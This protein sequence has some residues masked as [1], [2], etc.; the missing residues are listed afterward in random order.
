MTAAQLL[1]IVVAGWGLTFGLEYFL[2]PRP[3]L[4]ARPAGAH[5]IHLGLWLFAVGVPLFA[6][7]RPLLILALALA[8]WVVIVTVS[9]V[10]HDRLKEPL[11]FTDLA[12]VFY[13]TRHPRLYV[14]FFGVARFLLCGGV[15][16][17]VAFGLW[18]LEQGGRSSLPDVWLALLAAA[19]ALLGALLIWVG[20]RTA[21]EPT[22]DPVADIRRFGLIATLWLYRRVERRPRTGAVVTPFTTASVETPD[23]PDLVAIQSESFFDARR[24][25]PS[26]RPDVL[27]NFD[28]I[29][30]V[31]RAEG[32][33]LVPAWGANTVRTEFSFLSGLASEALGIDRFNP[34]RRLARGP[35]VTLVGHL[36]RLGY[37]TVCVHPYLSS[38]YARNQVFP[39]LGFDD[40]ID[41]RSFS[42]SDRVGPYVGDAAV[43]AAIM[44]L[45]GESDRPIFVFAITMENHGPLHLESVGPDEAANYMI[46]VAP[47]SSLHDLTAYLR[48]LKNA[49]RMLGTLKNWMDS[50]SRPVHLCWY[51]DHVPILSKA[52]EATAPPGGDTD[53]LLWSNRQNGEG[54]HGDVG[55]EAL[56]PLLLHAAGL[57]RGQTPAR[58]ISPR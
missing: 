29:R 45:A 24:L 52:Y 22:L 44:R 42:D 48:H 54:Y 13:A 17:A 37:R 11:V 36:R 43:A 30:R 20:D 12:F 40:F 46:D 3:R 8:F 50:R 56:G 26:I 49:D 35:L 7:Q 33:L 14:P 39:L 19:S 1:C 10:K 5:A 38:F 23:R 32:R 6:L 21:G 53:Y 58:G 41:V 27:E 55:I 31:A 2:T 25:H 57:M 16:F 47:S 9:N 34:Y 15:G 51:G 18:R 28:A 4:L